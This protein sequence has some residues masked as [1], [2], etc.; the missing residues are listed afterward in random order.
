[1]A[2]KSSPTLRARELGSRLRE[3]RHNAG[4]SVEDVAGRLYCS[5]AK[6]SRIETAGRA[7]SLRDVNDLC[8]IYGAPEDEREHLMSLA[9]E[10]KQ[11]AWWQ[12]YDL[13]FSNYIGLEAAASAISDFTIGFVPGLLQ[14]EDYAQALIEGLRPT[15][16]AET[17][18]QVVA[19]RMTRQLLLTQDQPPRLWAVIDEAA[20]HRVVG[21]PSVM[22]AQLAV[23]VQKAKLGNVTVQVVPFGAGAHP[24]L[25]SQFTILD[26]DQPGLTGV[27]YVEGLVG[28][29]YLERPHDIE[30]Y[31]S[32]FD[33]LRALALGPRDSIALVESVAQSYR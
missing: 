2:G 6:I 1:M 11:P 10:S 4:L 13:P 30:R 17:M 16:D 19:S 7:V 8:G 26:F 12:Q 22:N 24:G 21:D 15:M 32:S 14:T 27:A 31:R 3:L 18:Q 23:V 29:L 9:R 20:L 33:Q 28:Y 5:A 25:D